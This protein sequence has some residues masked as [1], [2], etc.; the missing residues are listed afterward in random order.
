MAVAE[1]EGTCRVGTEHR[2]EL[3]ADDGADTQPAGEAAGV[4]GTASA[5]GEQAE[6]GRVQTMLAQ[7]LADRLGD[8]G[9]D[10]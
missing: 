1:I 3:E 9:I 8:T 4:Y 2:T 6:L 10:R 5:Q 7:M